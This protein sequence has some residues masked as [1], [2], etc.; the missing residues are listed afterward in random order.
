M[1]GPIDRQI[2]ACVCIGMD[3]LIGFAEVARRL[4]RKQPRQ[5]SMPPPAEL[6]H[7]AKASASAS[8]SRASDSGSE[9]Q[10]QPVAFAGFARG[11]VLT[12]P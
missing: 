3:R 1:S 8:G 9:R 5:P 2:C 7:C 11:G 4:A 10:L 12:A 6:L